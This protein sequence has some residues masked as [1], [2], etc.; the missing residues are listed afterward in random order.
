MADDTHDDNDNGMKPQDGQS[1]VNPLP[2]DNDTPFSPPTDPV[3]E[4]TEDSDIQAERGQLES[5]H[6]ATDSNIDSHETYDEGLAGAAEAEE[7]N[8]GDTVIGYDPNN[9]QREP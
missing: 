4:T 7:P 1:L 3:D 6:Q 2:E 5:T 9:D 8:A